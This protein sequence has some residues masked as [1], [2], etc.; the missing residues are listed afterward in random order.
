[1]TSFVFVLMG[2]C[3]GI[4][5]SSLAYILISRSAVSRW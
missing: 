2:F 4:G 1:M 3:A 5:V